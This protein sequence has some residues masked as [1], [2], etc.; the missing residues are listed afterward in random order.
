MAR[1]KK[2]EGNRVVKGSHLTIT[3]DADNYPIN[4]EWDDEQ[5]LKDVQNAIASLENSATITEEPV[6]KS[7]KKKTIA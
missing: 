6:K 2:A 4:L 7:R 1:T 5:L 3:Y